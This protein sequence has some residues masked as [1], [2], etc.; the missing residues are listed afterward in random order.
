[1]SG[2]KPT[3]SRQ[4]I[5]AMS[6]ILAIVAS[7]LIGTMPLIIRVKLHAISARKGSSSLVTIALFIVSAVIV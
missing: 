3:Y 7:F 5:R 4:Q 2:G 6:I 1:M